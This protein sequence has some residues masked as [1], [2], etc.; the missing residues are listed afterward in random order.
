MK[1][2]IRCA[3]IKVFKSNTNIISETNLKNLSDKEDEQE[4]L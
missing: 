4:E 2:K 1:A 3:F